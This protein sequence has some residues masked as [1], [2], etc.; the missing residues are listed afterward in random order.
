MDQAIVFALAL[1]VPAA[2]AL[3]S[4]PFFLIDAL[5]TRGE[6]TVADAH[7]TAA[8]LLQYGWG[9]PAFVLAQIFNRAFF[10]RQDTRTPM[11][12]GLITVGLNLALGLTLFWLFGVPG[13]AA[14]TAAAWWMNVALMAHR[15]HRSGHY[16]PSPRAVSKALR[17]LA[18]SAAM[19]VLLGLA[20]HY[21][22]LIE[23]ALGPV[24]FH[25]PKELAIVL[26]CGVAGGAYPF[27]L[28]AFG[29]L[30]LTEI[31][32]AFKRVRGQKSA[33]PADL[34]EA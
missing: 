3:T 4:I 19:G 34:S 25:H 28:F 7:Q 26:V 24:S 23:H 6:F 2:V 10:A 11:R 27:L 8:A 31:K 5:Y 18:A 12:F 32:A 22:P 30:T 33:P 14:A 9:V 29:G 15:L 20:S 16:T 1:C 21:R 13:I 17:I